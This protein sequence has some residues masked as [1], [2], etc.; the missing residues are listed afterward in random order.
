MKILI[1]TA[2]EQEASVLV[3]QLLHERLIGCGNILPSMQSIYRW[4]GAVQRDQEVM[5]VM[6]T[7]T[8]MSDNAFDRLRELHS[9]EVPKIYT[10]DADRVL[11]SYLSWL[12]DETKG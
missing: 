5:I 3:E 2:P 6:E 10:L 4:N 7:T 1:T 8:Q 12:S 9:Y 11:E